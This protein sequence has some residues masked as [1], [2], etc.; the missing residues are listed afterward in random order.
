MP[1]IELENLSVTYLDRKHNEYPVLKNISGYFE[2]GSINVISGASGTGKT[3]LLRAI[4][5]QFD[6]D[7][8]IRFDGVDVLK[9]SKNEKTSIAYIDQ[10]NFLF[11]NKIVY[12]ILAFPL[13]QQHKKPDEIDVEVK[14]MAVLLGISDL[15]TRKPRQLSPGQKQKV[16]IGKALIK[17]PQ[18]CLFDEPFSNLDEESKTSCLLFIRKMAKEKGATILLVSHSEKEADL[19]GAAIYSLNENGLVKVRDAIEKSELDEK[20]QVEMPKEQAKLPINRKQLFKDILKNRYR[21]LLLIGLMLFLFVLPLIAVSVWNDLTLA[22]FFAD[23][24]NYVDGAMTESGQ[25]LYKSIVINFTLFYSACLLVFAIGLSGVSHTF[26]QLCW[27]EGIQFFNSFGKGIKQNSLRFI[28]LMVFMD[29]IFIA[30]GF[31]FVSVNALWPVIVVAAVGGF[32]FLPIV[33]VCF[34]YS[35]IYQNP[36]PKAFINSA[37]LAIK[38]YPTTLLFSI[39]FILPFLIGFIPY[40]LSIVKAV[41]LVIVMVIILPL[42][43]LTG[44]LVLNSIF[45]KEINIEKHKEIY[46]KGLY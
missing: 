16:A 3:T 5:S 34:G 10:Q 2:S 20:P 8:V 17:N 11:Q 13:K 35:A 40:G 4:A 39:I 37:I 41:I 29:I 18:V 31:L 33:F 12:D 46:R 7:G 24:T 27:G 21:I 44:G 22:S 28:L 15:L 1:K 6:Y 38:H 9:Q 14:K 43:L 36:F 25:S 45:D 30:A 19:L 42:L 26:R 32:V 23:S